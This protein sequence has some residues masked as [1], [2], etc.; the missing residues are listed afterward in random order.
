MVQPVAV[1]A[2]FPVFSLVRL[3]LN[4]LRTWKLNIPCQN[5]AYIQHIA[6]QDSPF[7]QT[8]NNISVLELSSQQHLFQPTFL[9]YMQVQKQTGT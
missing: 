5:N 7:F 2:L 9:L 1:I 8:N 6:D 3:R 4:A